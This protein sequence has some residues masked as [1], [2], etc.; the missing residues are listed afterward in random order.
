MS[1]A[2]GIWC[3]LLLVPA[4]VLHRASLRDDLEL[5]ERYLLN[6]GYEGYIFDCDGTLADT[7]PLHY[8][9]W[10]HALKRAG[11]SFEFSWE[12]FLS[13][14]GM[15][16]ENTVLELNRQF[17]MEMNPVL[18]ASAQRE[19]YELAIDGVSAIDAVVDLAREAQKNRR[20]S[21]ASGSRRQHVERTLTA[22]G[23][24]ELFDVIVTP[25]DVERGKPAP[26][27]FLLAAERMNVTPSRCLVIEDSELGV[28][29]AERAG[30]HALY[31]ESP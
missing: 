10:L 25:A 15:S 21:V 18:V 31:L 28:I 9:S 1:V 14:A 6:E 27:M 8:E 2:A 7:M 16:L 4:P 30:M 5:T 12:L 20:V 13:R 26:D 23:V 24:R 19:V 3:A 11:A 17:Q 22:I 29:A